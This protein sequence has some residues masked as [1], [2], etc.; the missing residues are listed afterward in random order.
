MTFKLKTLTLTN[1]DSTTQLFWG[2]KALT[3][4]DVATANRCVLLPQ[5]P[6][7]KLLTDVDKHWLMG[8][9][10]VADNEFV[11]VSA[12]S[13]R[14][15]DKMV[16]S[17][18]SFCVVYCNNKNTVKGSNS[19]RYDRV[20]VFDRTGLLFSFVGSIAT[21]DTPHLMRFLHHNTD[22]YLLARV[23]YGTLGLFNLSQPRRPDHASGVNDGS[24][25]D[26]TTTIT[27]SEAIAAL[28]N[29][30]RTV[31]DI[32]RLY[33]VNRYLVNLWRPNCYLKGLHL[34][35]LQEHDGGDTN[36]NTNTSSD[37]NKVMSQTYLVVTGWVWHPISICY[38]IPL[39]KLLTAERCLNFD[40]RAGDNLFGFK[41]RH[42]LGGSD[43][44]GFND[45]GLPLD[46]ISL[47][48]NYSGLRLEMNGSS[49]CFSWLILDKY[50]WTDI[51]R[52]TATQSTIPCLSRL[53]GMQG[54]QGTHVPN[55]LELLLQSYQTE[56]RQSQLRQLQEKMRTDRYHGTDE[57]TAV[58]LVHVNN[59]M[60]QAKQQ[61]L[62][63]AMHDEN[64][65][66]LQLLSDSCHYS[67]RR[68]GRK[69]KFTG[70]LSANWYSH[71]SLHD[72][73]LT[74]AI[75]TYFQRPRD[76]QLSFSHSETVTVLL[77]QHDESDCVA[78]ER[79]FKYYVNSS[80]DVDYHQQ[81]ADYHQQDVD[82]NSQHVVTTVKAYYEL[83]ADVHETLR[84]AKEL[85]SLHF[86]TAC[87][88][89][90]DWDDDYE[91]ATA[92]WAGAVVN[93][94]ASELRKLRELGID[95]KYFSQQGCRSGWTYDDKCS[96]V[97]PDYDYDTQDYHNL[98]IDF[99][100]LFSDLISNLTITV[101]LQ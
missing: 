35:T 65:E 38:H 94:H 70:L 43:D 2:K 90:T 7:L 78:T 68:D 75:H 17:Q 9:N 44:V 74:S 85:L 60:D 29:D 96:I 95:S 58:L 50:D 62:T 66:T 1:G 28:D 24:G 82:D 97:E 18:A 61:L 23:I 86:T 83:K 55:L 84:A 20:Y 101:T 4:D 59:D 48:P 80:D 39:D 47:L 25:S 64:T 12:S 36:S 69:P 91:A 26:I 73:L 99:K 67:A 100:R 34:A 21:H 14:S 71:S 16:K 52:F 37:G 57:T 33:D 89:A 88:P 3:G 81:D 32:S 92:K 22:T 11:T 15:K 53:Q 46:Y 54:M 8:D 93:I 72:Y 5:F 79:L 56:Q 49:Q 31:D 41:R 40:L 98:V 51:C 45:I 30:H 27:F 63:T 10:T 6:T 42:E 77:S 87:A 19:S 76:T 13:K